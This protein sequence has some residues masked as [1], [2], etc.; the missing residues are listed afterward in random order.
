[1]GWGGEECIRGFEQKQSMD[2]GRN[3]CRDNL[4]L[5]HRRVK[6][7]RNRRRIQSSGLEETGQTLWVGTLSSSGL[8]SPP[9][10]PSPFG[11]EAAFLRSAATAL[12]R[13]RAVWMELPWTRTWSGWI[14]PPWW[15]IP[16]NTFDGNVAG[17]LL[18]KVPTLATTLNQHRKQ[19]L[20]WLLG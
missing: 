10:T 16:A 17:E 14:T 20:V 9:F 6:V 15:G 11:W 13:A 4:C 7:H 19:P 8:M 3:S 18:E 5:L 12:C 1:M 2:G